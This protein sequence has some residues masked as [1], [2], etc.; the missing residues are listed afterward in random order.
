[1]KIKHLVLASVV[2]LTMGYGGA[3]AGSV[4]HVFSS[5]T[6]AKSSEVNDNFDYLA[7]RS[8][9]LSGSNLYYSGGNVGIGT[10]NN[11]SCKLAVGG[12]IRWGGIDAPPYAYLGQDRAGLYIEQDGIA[13]DSNSERIRLQSA[14]GGGVCGTNPNYS[15]FYLDPTNGFAF[16]ASGTGNSNVGIGRTSPSYPLHMGSGAYVST[17]GVW[18]NASSREYKQDISNL[19]LESAQAALEQLN[20]VTFAYK[21]APGELHVG[22]IAEDVPDLVATKDR[23]G[24]S[25]MDTIA[26]VT[27]VVQDQQKTIKEQ[28][29]QIQTQNQEIQTLKLLLQKTVAGL[30]SI[31]QQ[32]NY[33]SSANQQPIVNPAGSNGF[34]GSA[35][36]CN[37]CYEIIHEFSGSGMT[38][39]SSKDF[40][41]P[42]SR[43]FFNS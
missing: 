21:N 39:M 25:P 7:D 40:P 15:Q 27:K 13:S 41:E 23:N 9:D 14:K 29:Q 34:C 42:L 30:S 38:E 31:Q 26:V 6:T 28:A 4:P 24:L 43:S 10:T 20:P 36:G 1:M 37:V 22:F 12:C 11:S 32:V 18:T 35:S 5:G 3:N 16:M 19:P 2:V 17:G 33:L 8:W